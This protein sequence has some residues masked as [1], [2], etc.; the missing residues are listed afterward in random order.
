ML[1]FGLLFLFGL[2]LSACCLGVALWGFW[3]RQRRLVLFALFGLLLYWTPV[4][5][6]CYA[7][8]RFIEEETRKNG[9]ELPSWAP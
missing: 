6:L 4:L 9:G 1:I 5:L 8:Q 7:D 2:L 3:R